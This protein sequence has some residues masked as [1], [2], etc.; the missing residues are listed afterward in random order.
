MLAVMNK[1]EEAMSSNERIEL[2]HLRARLSA[3]GVSCNSSGEFDIL[4]I[5]AGNGNGWEFDEAVLRDSLAL[6]EGVDCF[7]DHSFNQRSI[8]DLAGV[9]SQ[10]LWEPVQRGIRL[11]LKPVGPSAKLLVEL[12]EQML[13]TL[14]S[15]CSSTFR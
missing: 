8:R 2:P 11:R 15:F 4:A 5:S 7:I 6:W 13:I 12:G 3:P 1:E 9:C 10:P 14:I